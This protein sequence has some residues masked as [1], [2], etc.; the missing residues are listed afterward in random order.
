[1]QL[2]EAIETG[3]SKFVPKQEEVLW[4]HKILIKWKSKVLGFVKVEDLS[5]AL[6]DKT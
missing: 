6:E 2:Q 3:L 1:M 4:V 5:M